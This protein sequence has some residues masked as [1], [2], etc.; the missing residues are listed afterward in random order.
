MSRVSVRDFSFRYRRDQRPILADINLDFSS[1]ERILILGPSG[2]G[3]STLL[4]ALMRLYTAF[5]IYFAQGEILFDGRP[6]EELS[7]RELLELFGVVFQSPAHQF[8]LKYP[9]DEA[10]FGLEN[11][12]IEPAEMP[13]LIDRAFGRFG[14]VKRDHSIRMLSGGEQQT[15]A[16][17]STTVLESRMLVMDEPTAHLD[18]FGR[19][20]FRR[21]L[22]SWLSG[23]KGFLLVEHHIDLW[24]DLV[25]RILVMDDR[26][27]ILFDEKGTTVLSRER[28]LLS[29]MGVWLPEQRTFPSGS[30]V[31][32]QLKRAAPPAA[33][34]PGLD[35]PTESGIAATPA[36]E[37]RDA[38]IGYEKKKVVKKLNFQVEKGEL[39]ALV[40]RNGCGKSTVLQSLSGLSDLQGGSIHLDGE[41]YRKPKKR[42]PS[43]G[44]L[45]TSFRIRSISLSIPQCRM[46]SGI[47][48]FRKPFRLNGRRNSSTG[49]GF[50]RNA[51]RI[52]LPFP[53]GRKGD[54]P[55]FLSWREITPSTFW[56]NPHSVRMRGLQNSWSARS[57]SFPDRERRL[58]LSA[59]TFLSLRICSAGLLF[60][61][62]GGLFLTVLPRSFQTALMIFW[63]SGELPCDE[64]V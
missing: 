5:D 19:K 9:E 62:R 17:A 61:M 25:E 14:F 63:I 7:R 12:Q 38:V 11:L 24:L 57:V 51:G 1:D 8:C 46:R 44:R 41:S 23:D 40:G 13:G 45:P 60:C 32:A 27:R 49:T 4:L 36:L 56:M 34:S 42:S 55:W 43:T 28:N 39:V 3:K 50:L 15:L 47:P 6:A 22:Q 21:S 26:G 33:V 10:A 18:P 2:G 30:P 58:S 37:F 53:G 35:C 29:R 20:Q 54:S 16:A 48:L 64:S 52:P 59:M 31:A